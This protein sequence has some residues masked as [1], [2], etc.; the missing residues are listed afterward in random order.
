MKTASE[1]EQLLLSA[2]PARKVDGPVAPHSCEECDELQ[3]ALG[4][5]TWSEV[6]AD[7]IE[8]HDDVLPLLTHDAYLVFLPA[9]LRQGVRS[10]SGAAAGMVQVSLRRRPNTQGFTREQAAAIIEAARY[11][12]TQNIYGASDPVNVESLTD[13][14]RIWTQVAV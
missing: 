1:I 11:I 12:S 7:F 8:E 13:I 2:F 10:P 5:A 14:T 9:W 4:A 6:S 3:Q